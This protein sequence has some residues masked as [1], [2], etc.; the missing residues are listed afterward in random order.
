VK[1]LRDRFVET[2][3]DDPTVRGAR[4]LRRSGRS[5]DLTGMFYENS[6]LLTFAGLTLGVFVSKKFFLVPVALGV[7]LAQEYVKSRVLERAGRR[8]SR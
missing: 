2:F 1:T 7:T 5:K 3:A 4:K 8:A 6:A